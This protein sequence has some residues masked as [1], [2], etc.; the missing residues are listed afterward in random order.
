[1]RRD[2]RREKEE[3]KM[4]ILVKAR[5]TFGNLIQVLLRK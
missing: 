2:I 3:T 1:M 4:K 5:Q